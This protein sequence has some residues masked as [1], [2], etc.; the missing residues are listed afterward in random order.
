[1][2]QGSPNAQMISTIVTFV[3]IGIVLMFRLRGLTKERPLRLGA[4]WVVPGIY[5]VIASLLYYQMPPRGMTILYCGVALALGA[6]LGWQRGR[7][8]HISV[9]PETETLKQK[10]SLASMFFLLGLIA[11]RTVARVEGA[12]WHFDVT[13]I[14]DVLV[15]FALGLLSVQRLEMYLRAKKLLEEARAGRPA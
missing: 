1:M 11:I 10:G 7:M 2:N 9:D 6:V 4:L 13:M 8:M 5:L 12:A 3:I 14:T 15:A